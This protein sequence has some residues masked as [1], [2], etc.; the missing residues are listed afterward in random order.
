M[1]QAIFEVRV[2]VHLCEDDDVRPE[3]REKTEETQAALPRQLLPKPGSTAQ[4][5][6]QLLSKPM[7]LAKPMLLGIEN[8]VVQALAVDIVA[9]M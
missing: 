8:E 3:P 5:N 7:P 1:N 6:V 2:F 9:L 4:P